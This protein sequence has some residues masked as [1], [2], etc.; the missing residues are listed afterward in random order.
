[1]YKTVTPFSMKKDFKMIFSLG[2]EL[3]VMSCLTLLL[4]EICIKNKTEKTS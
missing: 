2:K 4:Y 3:V 1:M